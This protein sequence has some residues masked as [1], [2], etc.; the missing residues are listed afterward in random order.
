LS[1]TLAVYCVLVVLASL[2]GGAVPSR[3]HLT[4]T[5][6]Q[7]MVS[8][9]AGLM[10]GVALL[11]MIP[12]AAHY[13]SIDATARWGVVGLLAMFFL[14]RAFHFHEHEMGMGHGE[15]EGHA[16]EHAHANEHAHEHPH[17]PLSREHPH[18]PFS[19]GWVGIAIGLSV[20]SLIDGVALASSTFAEAH[21]G[22]AHEGA[23]LPGVGT[24]LAV[25]LHKPLDALAI[26]SV[27][28]AAGWPL[29]TR[30]IVNA[31]FALV[32][33][34]GAALFVLGAG[35]GSGA[36]LGAALA[37]AAGAF[38]CISLGD[39]LPEVQFHRHDRLKL[40]AAL[41]AGVAIAYAVTFLEK[42]MHG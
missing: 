35:A 16:H 26:T 18:L 4:H 7:L 5:R 24:F 37:F 1:G 38:L 31:L 3:L 17:P 30:C 28:A 13:V 29:R 6:L 11:H 36:V 20:H 42:G 9:V 39:L 21:P 23:T 22:H 2:L 12:H 14:I 32:C 33:P 10:L 15:G 25:L 34:L 41:L 8:F 19:L 27:M 40:S